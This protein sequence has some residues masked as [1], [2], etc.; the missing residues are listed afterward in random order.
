M[1]LSGGSVKKSALANFIEFDCLLAL[2]DGSAVW[3]TAPLVLGRFYEME[4]LS[5]L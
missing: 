4:H 3:N 2:G 1:F 5:F